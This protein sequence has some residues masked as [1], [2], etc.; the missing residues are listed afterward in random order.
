[1]AIVLMTPPYAA[2][3]DD[4]GNPLSGG[5]VWTY[6]AGTLT[7]KATYT[8]QGGLTANSNPV[9][10]D[11]AGRAD[12]W[13]D[14]ASGYR[15]RVLTST[16][17]LV[18]DE[19]NILPFNNATGLSVL[20]NIAANTIVGNNTGSSAAPIALTTGQVNTML[21]L[22]GI[23]GM[24]SNLRINTAGATSVVTANAIQLIDSSNSGFIARNVNVTINTA[25]APGLLAIDT[26]S[27]AINTWYYVYVISNGTLVSAIASASSTSPTLPSGYNFRARVG[28]IRTSGTATVLR[29]IQQYN[30]KAQYR[31]T[32]SAPDTNLPIIV[33]GAAGN[34]T[35]P[36]YVSVSV[37]SFVPPTAYSIQGLTMSGGNGI[38]VAPTNGY[39]D[40]FSLTNPA[41]AGN[42]YQAPT[43]FSMILEGT[44]IW[45]ANNAAGCALACIGWEDNL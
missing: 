35:T 45:W 37:S 8:D 19:D 42:G 33:S 13:L 28:A 23:G 7:P 36:T 25:T 29:S 15:F 27:W 40:Y 18:R 31:R 1:M 41:M 17:V 26:G 43:Q 44:D 34:I 11:A 4:N 22:G 5:K 16:D 12:I 24:M 9:I 32:G 21:G 39:G 38:L 3:Y 30:N 20:G 10:L 14:N 2:F 6:Q